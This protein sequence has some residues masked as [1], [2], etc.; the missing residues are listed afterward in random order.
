MIDVEPALSG[1]TIIT[2]HGW[3]TLVLI[4]FLSNAFKNVSAGAVTV[5]VSLAGADD[6]ML[7]LAVSDTGQGVPAP[8]VP[9]LFAAFTQASKWRFGTG[10]GLFHVGELVSALGGV[11]GYQPNQPSGAIF[12]CTVPF[13]PAIALDQVVVVPAAQPPPAVAASSSHPAP[14]PAV[15]DET[16]SVAP[17]LAPP[18]EV[19]SDSPLAAFRVLVVED[20]DFMRDCTA[21][22]LRDDLGVGR[23][24]EAA[25]GVEGQQK[26][27]VEGERFT[28]ALIDLQMP[29]LDGLQC[30]R[31]VRGWE[32][33]HGTHVRAIAYTANGED[34]GTRGE[35]LAA[36]FDE[37]ANKPSHPQLLRE[38]LL[39]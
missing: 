27:T 26:L 39:G 20:D 12:W 30:I 22:Q 2:D 5:T 37:V 15:A 10:L 9:H 19:A 29:R 38:L 31:N 3:L 34:V 4:N 28:H 7:R 24:E 6:G 32:A 14:P 1:V 35:C 33:T 16:S 25:D 36:G 8:L 21:M 17:P 23:V 13:R 18:A 11:T